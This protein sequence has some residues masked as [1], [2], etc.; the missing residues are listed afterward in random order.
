MRTGHRE[1]PSGEL[2]RKQDATGRGGAERGDE[3]A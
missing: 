2:E 1:M 3:G